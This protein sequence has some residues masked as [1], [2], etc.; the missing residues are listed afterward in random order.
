MR[1][2]AF[3]LTILFMLTACASP[4][5]PTLIPVEVSKP[6]SQVPV[7]DGTFE[8]SL[9]VSEW[10]GHS[11]GNI[12][13]PLDPASG[14]PLPGRAP[15]LLGQTFFYAFS[16]DR[17]RLAVMSF[18]NENAYDSSL[19]L[20]DLPKW[21]TQ[22]L[23]LGLSGWASTMVFSPNG[24]QLAIA[25][26]ETHYKLT[27]VNI[28]DGTIK[29]Q[30]Q[31]DSFIP[32]L[33]FTESGD[34]L[35]LYRPTINLSNGL[36]AGSPQV[37]LLNAADLTLRWS[38]ELD[39]V[40]DG[41]F[42]RDET[43]TPTALY[44]P[45]Q[46]FYLS[47]GLVFAPDQDLLYIVHADRNQLTSVDFGAQKIKTTEIQSQLSWFERVLSLTA[48]IAHAKVADGTGKQ[49]TIS[50]D[51]QFLYIIG[52]NN[53]ST[54]DQQGN[55]DFRSSPLGLEI[56]RASDGKRIEHIETD[57]TEI[58]ISPEG[59][60]LYLRHWGNDQWSIPWTE[61]FDTSSRQIVT[62]KTGLSGAPA[63]LMNGEFLLVSTYSTS[64]TSNHMSVLKP[65]G[66]SVL[67]EWT[68]SEYVWWLTTP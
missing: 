46:S 59:R 31:M 1:L 42:P 51:G 58:S 39:N 65:D 60:F 36:T 17:H 37:F 56:I 68:G 32:R 2:F 64:E 33:K 16:P 63:L 49:V 54:L 3:L 14:T 66:S 35:I 30:K 53:A 10:K 12:L 34:A 22:R 20:I 27:L 45:G 21:K 28:E 8:T 13:Y 48:S 15:I 5:Q 19:L 23:E 61:V 57:S 24:K 11:E 52:V 40:R 44:E 26:G 50:P 29:A 4:A 55:W 7:L 6:E 62:R 18:S 38:A 67:S 9:L 41:I 43:V 47:P 25:H